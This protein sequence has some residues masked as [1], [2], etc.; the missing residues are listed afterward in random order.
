MASILSLQLRTIEQ[1]EE[2]VAAAY[3]L[4][5]FAAE[6]VADAN[7]KSSWCARA[8]SRHFASTLASRRHFDKIRLAIWLRRA[9]LDV[10]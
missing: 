7:S 5:A 2:S 8:T 6:R 10:K 3:T 9:Q 4:A 1:L